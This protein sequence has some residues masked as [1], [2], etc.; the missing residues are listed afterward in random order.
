M[1][2]FTHC[3]AGHD[4]RLPEAYLYLSGGG[5]VCRKCE[6]GKKA[7]RRPKTVERDIT[8]SFSG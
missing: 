3:T 8:G 4:L 2:I 1:T 7:K 5:R 6:Q